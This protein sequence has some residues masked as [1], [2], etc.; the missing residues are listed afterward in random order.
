M[1][2]QVIQLG[3]HDSMD[4]PPDKPYWTGRK[5]RLDTNRQVCTETGACVSPT[6]RSKVTVRSELLDQLSKWHKLNEDGV[7]S[8]I[9]YED[10]K[11]TILSDIDQL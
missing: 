10:L 11:K 2:A 1:W 7:V 9:E 5:R 6:K 3:K 8:D 4:D